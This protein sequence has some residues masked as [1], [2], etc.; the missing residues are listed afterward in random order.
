[1]AIDDVNLVK[2]PLIFFF[3]TL[4]L[5]SNYLRTVRIQTSLWVITSGIFISTSVFVKLTS[6]LG[7]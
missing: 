3:I 1:M 4:I 2:R 5:A 6:V 7:S